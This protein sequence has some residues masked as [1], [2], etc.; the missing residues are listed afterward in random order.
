ME[1]LKSSDF[2]GLN[3]NP[4]LQALGQEFAQQLYQEVQAKSMSPASE[5]RSQTNTFI[6]IDT[7][8]DSILNSIVPGL[9]KFNQKID[10]A[11]QGKEQSQDFSMVRLNSGSSNQS[12]NQGKNP[13]NDVMSSLDQVSQVK[14][15]P[16]NKSYAS[17]LMRQQAVMTKAR[18][19]AAFDLSND[20]S[21][22]MTSLSAAQN[23]VNSRSSMFTL[24][25]NILGTIKDMYR[26]L[27]SSG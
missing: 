6:K 3:T 14:L 21:N 24:A 26:T 25:N 2:L 12:G 10:S 23:L 17:D 1:L 27:S 20:H 8:Y 4:D 19:K 9:D 18:I 13:L 15:N 7:N 22:R 16:S 5:L 11:I